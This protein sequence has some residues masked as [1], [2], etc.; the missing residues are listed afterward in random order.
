MAGKTQKRCLICGRLFEI[1]TSAETTLH[2][3]SFADVPKKAGSFCLAC[4]AKIVK[5]A[6]DTHK[7]IKHA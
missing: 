3:A 7:K 5:E 2:A 6:Q 1:E 4:E